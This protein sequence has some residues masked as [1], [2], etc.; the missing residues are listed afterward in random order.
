VPPPGRQPRRR[1]HHS[2]GRRA[3]HDRCRR[4]GE[5]VAA[6]RPVSHFLS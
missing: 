4:I 5:M 1:H 6:R 2:A 3:D